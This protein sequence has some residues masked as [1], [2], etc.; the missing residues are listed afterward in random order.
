MHVGAPGGHF[1][2]ERLWVDIYREI[3]STE[4]ADKLNAAGLEWKY[5]LLTCGSTK[6]VRYGRRVTNIKER[7]SLH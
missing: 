3:I 6:E 4:L 5:L 1:C 2:S 7:L